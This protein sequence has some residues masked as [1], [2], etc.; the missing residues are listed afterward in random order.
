MVVLEVLGFFAATVI[1]TKGAVMAAVVAKEGIKGE[2][3]IPESK[4]LTLAEIE[5]QANKIT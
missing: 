4:G 2:E 5:A 3:K 1:T